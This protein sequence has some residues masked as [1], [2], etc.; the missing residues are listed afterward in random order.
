MQK[1][2]TMRKHMMWMVILFLSGLCGVSFA[3]EPRVGPGVRVVGN[4]EA[5]VR[6]FSTEGMVVR[7]M[8]LFSDRN[9][10]ALK[11]FPPVLEGCLYYEVPS[12]SA[13]TY[14]CLG[15]GELLAVA[16][17]NGKKDHTDKLAAIGFS[18]VAGVE[19]FQL[20]GEAPENI[21]GVFSKQVKAGEKITAPALTVIAGFSVQRDSGDTGEPLYNGIRLPRSW[22]PRYSQ[23][24][25]RSDAPLPVPYLQNPPR[26]IPI[27]VGR[28]LFVDD[29]LVE[30]TGLTR[31]YHHPQKYEGNPILKPETPLE[32]SGVN[33]LAVAG[34]KSGGLWW[35]SEKQ[36]FEF[37][38]EAGWV[39][40]IAYA[41]SRDGLTWERPSLPL[42]PGTNQV[43]PDEVKP[44]SWT[45]VRDYRAVDPKENFNHAL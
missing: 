27:D 3:G 26:L 24:L 7:M 23:E 15:A 14:E 10:M 21:F 20:F 6:M 38:Y 41:T 1:R 31:E 35:N 40:S 32:H 13:C 42:K 25:W 36:L 34:P 12:G 16:P 19:P 2:K 18:R 9:D 11:K 44:D 8:S 37:W 5:F 4:N 22:P 17:V 33:G 43:L 29:F 39:S 30:E 28:Q 45:V